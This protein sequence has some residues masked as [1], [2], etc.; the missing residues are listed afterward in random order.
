MTNMSQ[1]E[2]SEEEPE[3]AREAYVFL[4]F[5]DE[6]EN[7]IHEFQG[8]NLPAPSIGEEF[9]FTSIELDEESEETT[10]EHDQRYEVKDIFRQYANITTKDKSNFSPEALLIYYYITLKGVEEEG[11]AT[12]EKEAE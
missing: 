11:E 2:R 10:I 7:E 5:Q 12:E 1:S 4:Q 8:L 3:G 9:Q 6:E